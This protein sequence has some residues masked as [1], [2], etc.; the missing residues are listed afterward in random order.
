MTYKLLYVTAETA[1]EAKA[2]G[3]ALVAARLAA[4]ANV[5]EGM[6]PIFWWNGQ[7]QEG[8]EAVLIAKTRTDL[9][10][11]ATRLIVEAHSYELPCVVALPIE[12][13][14]QPFLDW[15][16]RET[17]AAGSSRPGADPSSTAGGG[18]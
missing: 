8:S 18:P 5:I 2:I 15:I 9:V 1:G 4:C 12:A 7:V 3:G 13:G 17:E 10:P 6:T 16:G 14:H 11:A